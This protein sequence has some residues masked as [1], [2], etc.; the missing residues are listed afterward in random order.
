MEQEIAINPLYI[1]ESAPNFKCLILAWIHWHVLFCIICSI[2]LNT[3]ICQYSLTV[4]VS[5]SGS[6]KWNFLNN[7]I[8]LL[9]GYHSHLKHAKKTHKILRML[10]CQDWEVSLKSRGVIVQQRSIIHLEKENWCNSITHGWICTKRDK[11]D[12][13]PGPNTLMCQPKLA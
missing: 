11:F 4:W 5:L 10:P 8:F 3:F 1:V 7:D 6:R 2:R 9:A 12:K 13:G